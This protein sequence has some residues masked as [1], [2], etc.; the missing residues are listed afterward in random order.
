M[1]AECPVLR[2]YPAKGSVLEDGVL[3]L[4]PL[5]PRTP[6][7]PTVLSVPT[8]LGNGP[9]TCEGAVSL[10][11]T[12]PTRNQTDPSETEQLRKGNP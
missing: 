8:R 5:G 7:P 6:Y 4:E 10:P 2:L 3:Y 12:S 11:A 1:A 9:G